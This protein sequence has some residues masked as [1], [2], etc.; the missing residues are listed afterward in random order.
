MEI[1]SEIGHLPLSDEE[2][3]ELSGSPA[4]AVAE[5]VAALE[6]LTARVRGEGLR[7]DPTAPISRALA[8]EAASVRIAGR[9]LAR[10]ADPGE[11]THPDKASR[12][13][14]KAIAL[15]GCCKRSPRCT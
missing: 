1:A 7:I 12:V 3:V 13:L 8:D 9:D 2:L 5:R 11:K 14:G 6:A 10:V 15:P 4:R